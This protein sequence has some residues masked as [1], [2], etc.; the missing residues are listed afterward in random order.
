MEDAKER[1]CHGMVREGTPI[2]PWSLSPERPELAPERPEWPE[3][4]E[5]TDG[6]ALDLADGTYDNFSPSF[7]HHE[8]HFLW[9]KL[10]LLRLFPT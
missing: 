10:T 7:I 4:N 2:R 1:T 6:F 9:S 5:T 3:W 8:L